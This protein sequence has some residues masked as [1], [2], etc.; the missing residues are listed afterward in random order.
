MAT[1]PAAVTTQDVQSPEEFFGHKMGADR[2]LA[3][4]DQLL[5]YYRHLDETSPR[6]ELVEMGSTTVGTFKFVFNALVS[7]PTE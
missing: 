2:Q 7:G 1:G 5:D 3:D 6:L 4:W